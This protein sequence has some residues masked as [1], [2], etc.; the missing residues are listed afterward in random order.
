MSCVWTAGEIWSTWNKP[1]DIHRARSKTESL[2]PDNN[3][4]TAVLPMGRGGWDRNMPTHTNT[5]REKVQ[6]GSLNHRHPFFHA[7]QACCNN[8]Y[9]PPGALFQANSL[10]L[11]NYIHCADQNNKLKHRGC[12]LEEMRS[13]Y[14]S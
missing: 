9:K 8:H 6:T 7:C 13:G 2:N 10:H 4:D 5:G 3:S 1:S 12:H 14:K 11:L